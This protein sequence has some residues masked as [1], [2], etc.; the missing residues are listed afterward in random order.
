MNVASVTIPV[1][2]VAADH[3]ETF[4]YTF[5]VL[6]AIGVAPVLMQLLDAVVDDP[7]IIFPPTC[8]PTS[9][10]TVNGD[11]NAT[12]FQFLTQ[13]LLVLSTVP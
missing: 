2:A 11:E 3:T 1:L 8:E 10:V 7:H 13:L 12:I 5:L 9:E 6:A 4:K